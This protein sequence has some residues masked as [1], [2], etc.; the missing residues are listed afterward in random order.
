MKKKQR[1]D[2]RKK[3]KKELRDPPG[4]TSPTANL[5]AGSPARPKQPSGDRNHRDVCTCVCVCLFVRVF[6]RCVAL[7][8]EENPYERKEIIFRVFPRDF[9]ALVRDRGKIARAIDRELFS[10]HDDERVERVLVSFLREKCGE[11]RV[12]WGG[13]DEGRLQQYFLATI[14]RR[15]TLSLVSCHAIMILLCRRYTTS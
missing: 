14:R 7:A 11:E 3:K 6:L 12:R 4:V 8:K 9:L 5:I 2:K 13:G 1:E 15:V 10:S